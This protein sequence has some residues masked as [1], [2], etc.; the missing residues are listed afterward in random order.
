MSKVYFSGDQQSLLAKLQDVVNEYGDRV[1][2]LD[3]AVVFDAATRVLY[4]K[5]Q[6]TKGRVNVRRVKND[7]KS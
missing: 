3:M 6:E 1:S 5:A 4:S 7:A 2:F